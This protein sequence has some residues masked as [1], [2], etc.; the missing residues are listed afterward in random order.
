L[1]SIDEWPLMVEAGFDIR[2]LG[3]GHMMSYLFGDFIVSWLVGNEANSRSNA[4]RNGLLNLTLHGC[5]FTQQR[6]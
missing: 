6:G 5:Y 4:F 2:C 1:V 3:S